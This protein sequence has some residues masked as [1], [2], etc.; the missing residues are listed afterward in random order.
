MSCEVLNYSR[1][2]S[3]GVRGSLVLTHADRKIGDRKI[4]LAM[5]TRPS[6]IKRQRERDQKA[7]RRLKDERRMQRRAEGMSHSKGSNGETAEV[8]DMLAQPGQEPSPRE[9]SQ[10]NPQ[11][12]RQESP[13]ES[14]EESHCVPQ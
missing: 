6:N 13:E 3:S 2:R 5:K 7:R 14:P 9:S 12:S 10:E 11:E 4:A 8:L 1:S